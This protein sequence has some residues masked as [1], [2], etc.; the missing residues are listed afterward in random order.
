MDSPPSQVV[1]VATALN[2]LTVLEFHEPVAMAAAGSPDFQIERQDNKVFVKPTKSGASTDLFVWTSARRF[3]YELETTADT[4]DMNFAIDSALPATPPKAAPSEPTDEEADMIL[5]RFLLGAEEIR[6][7][8]SHPPKNKVSVRVEQVLQTRGRV[9]FRYKIE[10]NTKRIYH[11]NAP[12][13]FELQPALS[14]ASLPRFLRQQLDEHTLEQLGSTTQSL[15]PV[16]RATKTQDVDPG[17][18]TQGV[19][20][21]RVDQVSPVILQLMFDSQ[22]KATVVL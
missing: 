21:V 19:V 4:K 5:I 17:A 14:T 18:S 11:V 2:H 8:I 1:H 10:N 16:A 22:V 7:S 20:I 15:L 3:V 9:Y 6:G 13:V 12:T